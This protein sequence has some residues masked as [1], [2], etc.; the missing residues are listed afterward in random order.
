MKRFSSLR[1]SDS[2]FVSSRAFFSVPPCRSLPSGS[3]E[4]I[5]VGVTPSSQRL[6]VNQK[7][8]N[9]KFAASGLLPLRSSGASADGPPARNDGRGRGT[10]LVLALRH[11]H[12][13]AVER[14]ARDELAGEP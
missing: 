6:C 4:A 11:L 9:M 12:P 14:V 7:A 10:G 5:P 2:I 8:A 3:P 13:D 1:R